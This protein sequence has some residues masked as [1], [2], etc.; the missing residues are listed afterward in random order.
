MPGISGSQLDGDE[1][2]RGHNGC[3]QDSRGAVAQSVDVVVTIIVAVTRASMRV[4]VH[5]LNSTRR[6]ASPDSAAATVS[7][8]MQPDVRFSLREPETQLTHPRPAPTIK[9][10]TGFRKIPGG[11]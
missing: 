3:A 1:R 9:L 4:E 10:M 6:K 8:V 2:K 5:R 7:P 11:Q